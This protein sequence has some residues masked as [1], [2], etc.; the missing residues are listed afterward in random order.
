MTDGGPTAVM[1]MEHGQIK[2]FLEELN[3]RVLGGESK[4]LDELTT[5]LLEVLHSHNHKE[6]NILYP[7]IDR[8]V[9]DEERKKVLG[10][11]ANVAP[12]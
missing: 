11:M 9:T 2:G 3:A 8:M 1:K 6:E 7:A 4:G 10:D 5:G 12:T